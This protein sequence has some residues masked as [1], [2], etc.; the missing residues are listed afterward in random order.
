MILANFTFLLAPMEKLVEVYTEMP[1]AYWAILAA[2][3]MMCFTVMFVFQCIGTTTVLLFSMLLAEH[4]RIV[5]LGTPG[6]YRAKQG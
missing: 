4:W 6:G 2:V 1:A 5:L 3:F